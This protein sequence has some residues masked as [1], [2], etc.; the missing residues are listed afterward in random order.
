MSPLAVLIITRKWWAVLIV[1]AGGALKLFLPALPAVG[2][3]TGD[4]SPGPLHT[5]HNNTEKGR[6]RL[7]HPHPPP[8]VATRAAPRAGLPHI[9]RIHLVPSPATEGGGG[10]GGLP[11][12]IG[13]E[14][15]RCATY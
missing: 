15:R 13:R 7:H 10:P 14:H 3:S 8:R 12:K 11:E 4:R 6:G 9:P 1:I 5:Q 2:V